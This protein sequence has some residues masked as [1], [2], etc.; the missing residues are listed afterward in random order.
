MKTIVRYGAYPVVLS[1]CVALYHFLLNIGAGLH[2]AS[3]SSVFIGALLMMILEYRFPHRRAWLPRRADVWQDAIFMI[4]IQAALPKLLAFALAVKLV[5]LLEPHGFAVSGVWPGS[6]SVPSQMLLMMLIADGFRY[7]LH[8]FAHEWECLWRF[9]AVHHSPHTLYWLNVGRFHPID[10]AL[11][12]FLDALPFIVLGVSESVLGL[13]FV[14][15]AVNGFFQHG[16][17]DVRLGILNYIVSGP[18]LHR[19]H[20]SMKKEESNHNYGN[21][22]IVWDL[23]FGTWYLPKGRHVGDLGLINR[24]YPS[25]F[26]AQMKTPFIPG[27]DKQAEPIERV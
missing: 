16:N 21:N 12:F 6:W 9:H 1:A 20:H 7:W 2:L 18:E 22:L 10:K 11:Q 26:V 15:Y 13:Y 25:N 24:H 14:C 23:F 5:E 8:R 17:V 4:L 3:Y 27:V 19:W